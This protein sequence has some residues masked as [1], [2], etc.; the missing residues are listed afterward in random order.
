M[1]LN[2]LY[3]KNFISFEEQEYVFKRGVPVLIQG[4]NYYREGQE[5]NGSGKTALQAG[6][7]YC[8]LKTTSRKERDVNLIRRGYK[9]S[10]LKLNVE[11]PIRK[12]TLKILREINLKGS[13]TCRIEINNEEL[14]D[15]KKGNGT[16]DE[17][18]NF[19]MKWFAFEDKEDLK[20]YYIMNKESH[21]SFFKSSNTKKLELIARLY[22]FS[23]I[24]NAVIKLNNKISEKEKEVSKLQEEI[25]K[26]EG[27]IEANEESIESSSSKKDWEKQKEL[28]IKE[29]DVE[30]I[31]EEKLLKEL[32]NDIFKN[33]KEK[34]SL[35]NEIGKINNEINEVTKD[36]KEKSKEF[37]GNI[38]KLEAK[39]EDSQSLIDESNDIKDSYNQEL[40]KINKKLSS[41]NKNLM[42]SVV[43]PNCEFEFLPGKDVDVKEEEKR[44][45][46]I[47]ESLKSI[48]NSIKEC[49]ELI[50]NGKEQKLAFKEKIKNEQEKKQIKTKKIR[51]SLESIEENLNTKKKN[52]SSVEESIYAKEQKKKRYSDNIKTIKEEKANIIKE[53]YNDKYI[54]QLKEKNKEYL[55]DKTNKEDEVSLIEE[56][57]TSLKKWISDF[58]KFKMFL[59]NKVLLI[60]QNKINKCLKDM[61]S[62]LRVKIEGFKQNSDGTLKEQI[63]PYVLDNSDICSF[64]SFSGG[65]RARL[66]YAEI[67][68]IQELINN[69]H[70]H[71][72]LDLMW[73]DEINEGLDPLGTVNV[74][75]SLKHLNKTILLT[76]HVSVDDMY[77]NKIVVEN[78]N[79]VSKIQ[80]N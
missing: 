73:A 2:S 45:N 55:T 28:K 58:N 21:R 44:K 15:T 52:L 47:E 59:S 40:E 76:T 71:G 8:L 65:E 66:N 33:K 60:I 61:K 50:D 32:E 63:T 35:Q 72:G 75:K 34:D 74:L 56:E 54:L 18:N 37:E 46:E 39:K 6:V 12:E 5:S 80:T 69:S 24:D 27:K 22:D 26:I 42:D 19:I 48:N 31:N 29:K 70:P 11:C 10:I 41:I 51:E 38:E 36:L 25:Y 9:Q 53:E 7:E 49:Q 57:I 62:E 43:C 1:F 20:N 17:A 30:I 78:R 16:N 14:F 4:K 67:V 79:G 3:L 77:D 64:N 13:S 23:S 68:A